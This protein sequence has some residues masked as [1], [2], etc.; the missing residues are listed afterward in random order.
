MAPIDKLSV[1]LV[2]VFG[3][4]ILGERLSLAN[5]AGVSLIAAGAI[6]VAYGA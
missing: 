5:W 2:A 4:A 3:V 1:V 6:L